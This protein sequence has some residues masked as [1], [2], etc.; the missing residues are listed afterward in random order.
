M[1]GYIKM[2]YVKEEKQNLEQDAMQQIY[3][4][5]RTFEKRNI[6]SKFLD[7]LKNKSVSKK[8]SEEF[9]NSEFLNSER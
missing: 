5:L 9:L 3:Q 4:D 6:F 2:K 8:L 1:K 7:G